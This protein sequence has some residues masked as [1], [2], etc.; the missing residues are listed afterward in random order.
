MSN[1]KVLR[2]N[3]KTVRDGLSRTGRQSSIQQVTKT[4]TREVSR[5]KA[6]TVVICM[7]PDAF[8]QL[9]AVM[10]VI[11]Q[12]L[13]QFLHSLKN[14]HDAAWVTE[15]FRAL[16]SI[17]FATMDDKNSRHSILKTTLH[18]FRQLH[19]GQSL[20]CSGFIIHFLVVIFRVC[21][22]FQSLATVLRCLG[23]PE[24]TS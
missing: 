16:L 10:A 13:C 2:R 21:W 4:V 14:K 9:S 3:L 7:S 6:V 22:L 17:I 23:S 19:F 15:D 11:P 5:C 20:R 8:C 1:R 24:S 12:D 18:A